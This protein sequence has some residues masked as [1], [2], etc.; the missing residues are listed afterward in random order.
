MEPALSPVAI[1]GQLKLPACSLDGAHG[2]YAMAAE[3]VRGGAQFL[4]GIAEFAERG[5]DVGVMLLRRRGG[6]GGSRGSNNTKDH[7]GKP[8]GKSQQL[9]FHNFLLGC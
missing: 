1:Q 9:L 3:I 2:F 8:G 4:I 7:Q 5:T 6:V